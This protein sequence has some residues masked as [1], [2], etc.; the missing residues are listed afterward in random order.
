MLYTIFT[1]KMG[2]PR[3]FIWARSWNTGEVTNNHNFFQH[4]T[5]NCLIIFMADGKKGQMKKK[6]NEIK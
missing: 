4:L 3:S 5:L 6:N 1:Y 2:T